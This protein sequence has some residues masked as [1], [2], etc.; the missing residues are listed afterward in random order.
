MADTALNPGDNDRVRGCPERVN[1]GWV[2]RDDILRGAG[3]HGGDG[4]WEAF[5]FAWS[6]LINPACGGVS[7]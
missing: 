5:S 2:R 3:K 6:R 1:G 4:Q 7:E